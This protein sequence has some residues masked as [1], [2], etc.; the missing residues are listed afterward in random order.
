MPR[1]KRVNDFRHAPSSRW[2]CI[3]RPDDKFKTVIRGEG[4]L[5]HDYGRPQR[6]GR[7]AGAFFIE[8]EFRMLAA[9][10]PLETT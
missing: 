9:G 1:P 4:A 7:L 2:T 3:C 8:I 5:F 10:A 6:N